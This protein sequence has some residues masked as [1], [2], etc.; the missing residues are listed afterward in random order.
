MIW[1]M[2]WKG[3]RHKFCLWLLLEFICFH[4]LIF[5]WSCSTKSCAK[6]W[7]NCNLNLYFRFPKKLAT[8]NLKRLVLSSPNWFPCWN[9]LKNV[10]TFPRKFAQGTDK[11]PERS[12]SLLSRSGVTSPLLNLVWENKK[13]KMKN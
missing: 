10:L 3:M 4:F 5:V 13:I 6:I 1:K 11:T 9:P 8:L 7:Q 2:N 12:R